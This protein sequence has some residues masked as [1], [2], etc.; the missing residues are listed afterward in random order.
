MRHSTFPR[1]GL[2]LFTVVAS[3]SMAT[4]VAAQAATD[5][6][7]AVAV[8]TDASQRV[9]PRPVSGA[10]TARDAGSNG[11]S[12]HRSILLDRRAAGLTRGANV[13]ARGET[14]APAPRQEN[15]STRT[16]TAMMIVGAAAIVLGA[17]VGDE[18]GTVLI[19]GGAG[20]GLFGLY[21]FLN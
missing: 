9:A 1:L 3:A 2:A 14:P 11:A 7:P 17:A 16:N 19:I 6:A 21:R 4:S 5:P 15:G 10:E 18:A 20:I 13:D 12:E 8:V